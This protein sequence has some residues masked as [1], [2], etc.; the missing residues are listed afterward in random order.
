M[1]QGIGWRRLEISLGGVFAFAL[2]ALL[3]LAPATQSVDAAVDRSVALSPKLVPATG[4]LFGV[5]AGPRDGRSWQGELEYLETKIGRRFALDRR[6]YR[7]D[8]AFPGDYEGWTVSKGR[9]PLLS[10]G[11]VTLDGRF[12]SWKQ[13]AAGG[14]DADIRAKARAAKAFGHR[15]MLIYTHE[16][17]IYSQPAA[18]FVAA[19]RRVVTIF[20]QEGAWNV[21]WVWTMTAHLF[22]PGGK[23][24]NHYYPGNAYVDWIAADAY[25]WYGDNHLGIKGAWRSFEEILTPF[26]NWAKWRG[27]PLMVPEYGSL[28]DWTTPSPLRRAQWFTDVGKT[29]KKWPQVK[30]IAYFNQGGFWFDTNEKGVPM[31]HSIAAFAA[32]GQDPY[33]NP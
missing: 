4:A 22:Q 32:L 3:L 21:V 28:E 1:G 2:T 8:A 16:A 19:W 24:P 30:G 23:D 29:L 20:R 33:F 14:Y 12:L 26:Y 17:N 18:D 7:W 15:F 25:N 6:F 13:I 9:I 11:P 27:K 5:A 31:P 10:W